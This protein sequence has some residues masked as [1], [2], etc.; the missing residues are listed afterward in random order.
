MYFTFLTIKT[1]DTSDQDPTNTKHLIA[2][3]EAN[4]ILLNDL[5][6]LLWSCLFFPSASL[7]A[8]PHRFID[9]VWKL[10]TSNAR[11]FSVV[12]HVR[13]SGRH[14][15]KCWH[16]ELPSF[17]FR[18]ESIFQKTLMSSLPAS[19]TV[20]LVGVGL[21]PLPFNHSWKSEN[22]V[23]KSK[24]VEQTCDTDYHTVFRCAEEGQI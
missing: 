19:C 14:I 2:N 5:L 22:R 17:Q 13:F 15:G 10:V 16:E 11:S 7:G 23:S 21:R 24:I 9:S 4:L 18:L 6:C 3:Q 1:W 20:V 8:A 12:I